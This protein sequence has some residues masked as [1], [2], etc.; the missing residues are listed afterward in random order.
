MFPPVSAAFRYLY[1]Q[2]NDTESRHTDLKARARYLPADVLGQQ[3]RLLGA[4]ML[5]NAI[6]W[7]VHCEAQ[8][9]PNVYDD[10][11]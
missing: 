9:K 8:R 5:L 3:L 7:Q 4:A 11:A 1:G 2:R 6:A 10:T